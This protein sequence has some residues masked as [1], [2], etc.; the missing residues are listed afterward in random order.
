LVGH[1]AAAVDQPDPKT[2]IVTL[3]DDVLF[4]DGTTLSARDVKATYEAIRDPSLG[5]VKRLFLEPVASIELVDRRTV[6]FHLKQPHAPFIQV[7]ASIGIAPAEG[8]RR[9]GDNFRNYLVGS[10]PFRF[11]EQAAD[12]HVLLERNSQWFGGKAGIKRLRFKIVPDAT[13]RVLEVLHGSADIIQNDLP[14]HVVARLEREDHLRVL[15]GE[16]SM[17]KYLAFNLQNEILADVRVRQAIAHAIDREPIIRHKLRELASPA[18]SFLHP[19][20]WA[21]EAQSKRYEHDPERARELLEEAGYPEP[22]KDSHRFTLVY[23]TSMDQTS[24]AVATILK[25]QLESVGIAMELRTNEWGVF[26]SDIKQGDFDLYTLTAV[27]VNDPDWYSFVFHSKSIPPNGANRPHYRDARVDA[28]LDAGKATSNQQDRA[29]L[30]REVQRITSESL[31]LLPLWYQHNVAVMAR[32]VQGYELVPDG[33]FRPLV[34]TTK[35][36]THSGK[37]R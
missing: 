32:R 9:H 2:Y 27:G 15:R 28:L 35:S 5:S 20:S 36:P 29:S 11:V 33:D 18:N 10:G 24:I 6:I 26:F 22:A 13:V 31:P 8:L 16:S 4:H 25:R 34:H 23:R 30:Y 12:E 37:T 19:D 14:S 21:Y 1:L 17:V 3:R 7:L